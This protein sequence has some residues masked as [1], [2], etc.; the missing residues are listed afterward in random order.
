M[1]PMQGMGISRDQNMGMTEPAPFIHAL[2]SYT[3]KMDRNR[4]VTPEPNAKERRRAVR[5]ELK[6]EK[7][8][9]DHLKKE[10]ITEPADE[11]A[12]KLKALSLFPSI[13]SAPRRH[14]MFPDVEVQDEEGGLEKQ[15]PMKMRGP[16]V[17]S[18]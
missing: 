5:G 10:R 14:R 6:H 8:R 13:Y 17:S 7:M 16:V 18:F 4:E 11:Y 15:R 9:E 3:A 12:M 1:Q 2:F